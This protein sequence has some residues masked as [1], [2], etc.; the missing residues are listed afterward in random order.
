MLQFISISQLLIYRTM[1]NGT[2]LY[3]AA[4]IVLVGN[5]KLSTYLRC[6]T[7]IELYCN[8]SFYAKHPLIQKQRRVGAFKS[9]KNAFAMCLSDAVLNCV[10]QG[11]EKLGVIAEAKLN[12]RNLQFSSILCMLALFS[13]LQLPIGSYFLMAFEKSTNSLSC[14]FNCTILPRQI[15]EGCLENYTFFVVQHCLL[16]IFKSL[17]FLPR[18]IIM[19]PSY[20]LIPIAQ[21]KIISNLI[22]LILQCQ[23]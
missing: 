4:S 7:S 10:K 20:I 13:I 2:C 6:I 5:E 17:S 16:I 12:A 9:L 8:S 18:K 21:T 15:T 14:M 19:L 22:L 1:A 3:N 23:I 11:E